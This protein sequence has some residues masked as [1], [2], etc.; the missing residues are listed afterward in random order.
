VARGSTAALVIAVLG[1]VLGII[2]YFGLIGTLGMV[3]GIGAIL[4]TRPNERT[5]T[6]IAAVVVGACATA[7]VLVWILIL[8]SISSMPK[9]SC[10]HVRSF[11]G[12]ELA[13]DADVLSGSLLEGG[14][15][16]DLARLERIR[17]VNGRYTVR[18]ADELEERDVLDEVA[19][20]VAD[21]AAGVEALPALTGEV[22]GVA[23]AR[24][25]TRAVD[26]RGRDVLAPLVAAGGESF[27]SRLDDFSSSAPEEPRERLMVE[28]DR[29]PTGAE[30]VLV[31]RARSTAFAE[32]AFANYLAEM[33]SGSLRL[34]SLREGT[35][36]TFRDRLDDEMRRLGL[37]LLVS[38]WD[39]TRWVPLAE[40]KPIGPAILRDVAV[41][42]SALAEGSGPVKLCLEHAPGFWEI[43]RVALGHAAPVAT[44]KV[45]PKVA[46][47][48]RGR[49]VLAELTAR[50]RVRVK[51]EPGEYVD[52]EFLEPARPA[53]GVGRE[54]RTV[55]VAVRGYYEVDLGGRGIVNALA[56]MK[57]RAGWRSLPRYALE[58]AE[59]KGSFAS[60]EGR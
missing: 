56:I 54:A 60:V 32:A 34:L 19:L 5:G 8:G 33:G 15:G 50:D 49:S 10:P 7:G 36:D 27:V 44:T 12:S 28:L 59:S 55:L 25:P 2:P 18:V 47:D 14:E 51:L 3:L 39:G 58:R 11:D 37:V 9:S 6:A 16:D 53:A 31:L 43:D 41:P 22:V 1:F 26:G 29:D 24:P 40:V 35:G 45:L 42:L 13:L 23:G 48:G 21:H 57:H 17:A 20:V 52:L 4:S 46:C 38:G 30:P